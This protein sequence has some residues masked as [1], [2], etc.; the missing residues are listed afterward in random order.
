MMTPETLQEPASTAWTIVSQCKSD[1]VVYY[2]DDP[3]Y[4]PPMQGDWCYCSTYLGELPQGMTLR[5]CWGWRFRGSQ[6]LD[7]RE[8]AKNT[9]TEKLID[10]N[11]RALQRLL[12]DKVDEIRKSFAPSCLDGQ[13]LRALKLQQAQDWLAPSTH[14][15]ETSEQSHAGAFLA[16]VAQARACTLE[17]AAKLIVARAQTQQKMWL[18]TE[19]FREQLSQLIEQAQTPTQL[20]EIRE[21]LLDAVYPE[22]SHQFK[23]PQSNTEPIDT[24]V[25][26]NTT[27]RLHEITRLKT[28]LREAIN[29]QR[30][31][32]HS[33]YVLGEQVWQHKLK[34]AQQWLSATASTPAQKVP[35]GFEMLQT[36][37]QAKGWSLN[38]ASEALLDAASAAA[39]TL[40][41]TERSKDQLLARIESLDTWADVQQI[42]QE[43]KDLGTSFPTPSAH[44]A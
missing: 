27:A 1:R 32:L 40:L 36:Y 11:R 10:H 38:E 31:H 44:T 34:Q 43:L 28:Q 5:N 9:A 17:Q 18:E 29:I 3:E 41:E 4:H 14:L 42:E 12:K 37:A 30:K 26:L 21:W 20:M 39:Q 23:Y 15:N 6:F 16:Q 22:L 24:S 7:A 8:P 19:R 25:A 13:A 33:A 35:L 2:T